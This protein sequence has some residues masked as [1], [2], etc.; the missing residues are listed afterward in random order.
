MKVQKIL[1]ALAVIALVVVGCKKG[2]KKKDGKKPEKVELA[3]GNSENL[4]LNISGMT[5]EIGCAKVIES[6]LAKQDGVLDAKV[7]FTD[8]L[9]TIK[10]DPAKTNK[11]SLMSFVEGIADNMYKVT[12]TEYK[13]TCD[14]SSKKACDKSKKACD[15]EKK[16]ECSSKKSA[17]ACGEGECPKDCCKA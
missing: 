2:P 5:C 10:Y 6:K 3:D 12:E 17:K 4:A 15:S 8:S 16:A 1:F 7:I 11:A 9:A 13:K 14:K